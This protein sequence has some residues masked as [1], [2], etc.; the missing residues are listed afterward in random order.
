MSF[1]EK[2]ILINCP[3]EKTFVFH[4]DTNNLKKITPSFIKAEILKI[5]LQSLKSYSDI[6]L[7][8]TQFGILKT[9]WKIKVEHGF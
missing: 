8:I 5:E 9:I 1:F 2:S 4:S 3:I 6:E 7:A